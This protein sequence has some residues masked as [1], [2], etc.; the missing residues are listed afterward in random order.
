MTQRRDREEEYGPGSPD[1]GL[2]Y[3]P[4]PEGEPAEECRPGSPD[5]GL[6][7]DPDPWADPE[8]DEADHDYRSGGFTADDAES[9]WEAAFRDGHITREQF[10]NRR[11]GGTVPQQTEA[12]AAGPAI[13][14]AVENVRAKLADPSPP[15]E[16]R[17]INE[18]VVVS[19]Q[20]MLDDKQTEPDESDPS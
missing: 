3:Q 16:Q 9:M 4:Y 2:S 19:L 13:R 15:P 10:Q 17:A 5:Y 12:P 1:Y 18:K 14:S 8:P 7:Y 11:R 20:R 6:S